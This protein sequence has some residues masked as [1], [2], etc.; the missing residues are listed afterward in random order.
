MKYFVL[1]TFIFI[2]LFC[3]AQRNKKKVET[4]YA[5]EYLASKFQNYDIVMLGESHWNKNQLDFLKQ[6]IPLLYKEGVR[7][8]AFE[9]LAFTAQDKIDKLIAADK[10]S[11]P[12]RDS[13]IAEKPHWF[14]KDYMDILYVLWKLNKS[15]KEKI[16]V[17]A[18]DCPSSFDN[19]I[20]RD[21]I[22]ADN[23]IKYYSKTKDK[24]LIYCGRNHGFTK[25]HQ[26][27]MPTEN[28]DRLGNIVYKNFTD[29]ITNIAFFPIIYN[30]ENEKYQFVSYKNNKSIFGMDL[31]NS[32]VAS[33]TIGDAYLQKCNNYSWG[34]F[35]DGAI[36]INK[37]MKLCK[38]H[39]N[40]QKKDRDNFY[41]M[42][43]TLKQTKIRYINE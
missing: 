42:L 26:C 24:M 16:K 13:I 39:K 6:N 30:D 22:M 37:K 5:N 20:D 1:L 12:L 11:Q 25:F 43:E 38:I 28:I 36:F 41:E 32:P 35:Y 10:F 7:C 34:S 21:S 40:L 29:K 33:S 3:I 4:Q 9:Y 8:F 18:L 27:R 17:L 19:S 2:P 23:A 31:K 15:N 14:V